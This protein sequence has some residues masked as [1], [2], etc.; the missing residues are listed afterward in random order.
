MPLAARV[1]RRRLRLHAA[2]GRCSPAS[3]CGSTAGEFVA[4]AG[5]NGGGKTTL[6]RLALGLERPT[7][8]RGAALRR[9]GRVVRRA[10]AHRLPRAAHAASAC[11]RRRP[12][13]RSSRPAARR[14]AWSG[15]C[16]AR[17]AR[18][19]PR[20]SSASA[21]PTARAP[22][23]RA[24]RRPAAARVHREGARGRT[25]AAR[26]RRADDRR[27]RRGA[28]GARRAARASSTASSA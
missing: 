11:T 7:R 4:I 25:A 27:R 2:A 13:A 5:P 19:S 16:A 6:L 9:A 14:C 23:A 10:L 3:T 20:R 1:R 28:G 17:T 8:G 24:L 22:A 15:G 26:A 21:S 18:P 12:C